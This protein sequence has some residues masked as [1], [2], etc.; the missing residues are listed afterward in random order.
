MA[1]ANRPSGYRPVRHLDGSAWNGQTELF[2]VSASDA[3]ALFVGDLVKFDGSADANG[4]AQITRVTANTDTPIGAVVGF[5]PLYSNLNV[6]QYRAASTFRQ[7][8]VA[9]DPSIVYE[10]QASGTYGV[11]TDAGLNVGSTFT[12][13]STTTGISGMQ[14]DLATKATTNTL[15]LKIIGV[16]QRVDNDVTD[17]SNLKLHV[18]LNSGAFRGGVTGV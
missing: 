1:N 2:S 6:A 9:A 15:P 14:I 10:A 7:A 17:T 18:S 5:V 4:V 11:T 12:A 3:T 8:F 16:V 13:G